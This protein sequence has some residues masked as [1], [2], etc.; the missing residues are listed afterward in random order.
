MR[1]N[2]LRIGDKAANGA[3]II[4]GTDKVKV[5]GVHL[6]YLYAKVRCPACNTI[7]IIVPSGPRRPGKWMD[8]EPALDNDLCACKCDP[9]PYLI[10]SQSRMFMSFQ[11]QELAAMGFLPTGRPLSNSPPRPAGL[12]EREPVESTRSNPAT[13]PNGQPVTDCSYLDGS[14]S[15]IDGPADFYVSRNTVSLSPGKP[16]QANFPAGGT[17][18]ATQY[19][20]TVERKQI[21]I[22]VPTRP[23]VD[24]LPMIRERQLA[25]ALEKLPSQKLENIGQITTNA[26]PNPEDAIWQRDYGQADFSSAATASLKQGVAFYPWAAWKGQGEI[27]QRYIDSTMLHETGHQVSEA[28]WK[29]PAMKQRFVD[30]IASDGQTPSQYAS[31]SANE[32]FAESANMYWSSKGTPCEAEGRKRY[33]ARFNYFDSI[34]K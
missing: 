15:R 25:K 23:A 9:K 3:T 12:A 14:K 20:A 29:D 13:G 5:G 32:D 4:E 28:L 2:Y 26:S 24:G 10:S 19:D 6:T 18:A 27:P 16:T 31:R 7:G 22:F 34:A 1:R 17:A 30:A 11:P 21:S 33:P 8:K